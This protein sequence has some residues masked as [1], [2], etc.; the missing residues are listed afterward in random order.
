[1][2]SNITRR[3]LLG[4]GAAALLPPV[5]MGLA[6]AP[7]VPST[8]AA[9]PMPLAD[10]TT[11]LGDAMDEVS[12]LLGEWSDGH[13]RAIIHADRDY[14]LQNVKCTMPRTTEQLI[15]AWLDQHDNLM[16]LTRRLRVAAGQRA[17]DHL[18]NLRMRA[19]GNENEARN[20][21]LRALLRDRRATS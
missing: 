12:M 6:A 19:S 18:S 9:E 4:T 20:A 5:A 11:R 14:W 8:V 21:M 7:P 3:A 17:V 10:V 2:T 16:H 13:F 1:M 15:E